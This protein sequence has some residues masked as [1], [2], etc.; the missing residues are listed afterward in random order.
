TTTPETSPNSPEN[1]R[2]ATRCCIPI[3]TTTLLSSSSATKSTPAPTNAQCSHIPTSSVDPR[4]NPVTNAPHRDTVI[5]LKHF[6]TFRFTP[7]NLAA[8]CGPTTTVA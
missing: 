2:A 5:I 8:N 4:A 3:A 1:S 6:P 7:R